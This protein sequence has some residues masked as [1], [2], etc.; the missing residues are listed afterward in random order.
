MIQQQERAEKFFR[1]IRRDAERR[2]KQIISQIDEYIAAET[3]KI[4]QAEL[5]SANERVQYETQRIQSQTNSQLAKETTEIS[6]ELAAYRSAITKEVFEQV[7]QKLAVF[8]K[9]QQYQ[10]WLSDGLGQMEKLLGAGMTVYAA[11]AQ[12]E[13]VEK[14]VAMAKV[15]CTVKADENIHLGGVRAEKGSKKVDDTL[16]SRLKSQE[17]WFYQNSGLSIAIQ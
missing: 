2:R 6:A 9:S 11:P 5:Q 12:V 4:E 7:A 14:A 10:Q 16:D 15:D 17:D 13:Q 3:E 8:V 1:A